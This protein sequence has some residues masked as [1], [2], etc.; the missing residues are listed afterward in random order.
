MIDIKYKWILKSQRYLHWINQVDF[1]TKDIWWDIYILETWETKKTRIFKFVYFIFRILWK[2]T[3]KHSSFN[4]KFWKD[5]IHLLEVEMIINEWL[6][7][8][9]FQ[10]YAIIL[11]IDAWRGMVWTINVILN[12]TTFGNFD[13]R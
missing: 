9:W 4:L 10:H 7:M 3:Q 5:Q 1:N 11:F 8:V 2:R 13:F 12:V 6:W